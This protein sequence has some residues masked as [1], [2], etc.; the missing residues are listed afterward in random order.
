MEFCAYYLNSA[1]RLKKDVVIAYKNKALPQEVGVQ[2]YEKGR[3]DHLADYAW[4]TDD[5]ISRGSWCY[6]QDMEIKSTAEVIHTFIDIVSKNGQ[7]LLNI[8]PR[9]DGTIPDDQQQVLLEMG[10]WLDVNGEAIY[11][12]RPWNVFGQGPTRLAKGGSFV[13]KLDYTADDIRFAR[14][15]DNKT[16][17]AI[18]LGWP[19]G[20]FKLESVQASSPVAAEL[21]GSSAKVELTV[22]D[23]GTLTVHPPAL[24]PD[25]RPCQHAYVFKMSG[26]DV[27]R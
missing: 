12:T 16:L 19:E 14:S 7:L 21:L 25:E 15:K 18:C 5:T 2:D 11:N 23:D 17:Y 27:K 4:L 3:L 1:T 6:T 26:F 9:A 10:Q 20:P 22:N 8:S 13:G 24:T